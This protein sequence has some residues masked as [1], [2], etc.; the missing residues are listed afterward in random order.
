MNQVVKDAEKHFVT[1]LI[2]ELSSRMVMT[3]TSIST[4]INYIAVMI[5]NED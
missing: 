1:Y 2:K 3:K 4:F 5:R